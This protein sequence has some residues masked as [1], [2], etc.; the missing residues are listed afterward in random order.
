[1][2]RR[3]N[4]ALDEL[5]ATLEPH[6][7]WPEGL[8]LILL[9]AGDAASVDDLRCR[10]QAALSRDGRTLRVLTPHDNQAV[11]A[12]LGELLDPPTAEVGAIWVELWRDGNSRSSVAELLELLNERRR[13]LEREVGRPTVLVLPADL[14]SQVYVFAPDLWTIR[15]FTAELPSPPIFTGGE[16][17]PASAPIEQ[18]FAIAPPSRAEHEW[19]RLVAHAKNDEHARIDLGDGVRAF[20]AA[21]ARGGL[22]SARRIALQVLTLV[23]RG[24]CDD[25]FRA[26]PDDHVLRLLDEMDSIPPH[27][28]LIVA[29]SMLGTAEIWA[30]D[31]PVAR[32]LIQRELEVSEK[33]ANA[34][35]HGAVAQRDLSRADRAEGSLEVDV[36]LDRLSV[37]D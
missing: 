9:F 34:A 20:Q 22:S 23:V 26:P 8:A 25:D 15:S 2:N 10:A 18:V 17:V 13:V 19:A 36:P 28:D 33:L 6:I 24:N 1:V 3:A 7:D 12:L 37:D 35:P 29:L 4:T 32:G 21:M 11:P 31:T 27:Q 14:R 5:W 16:P 30:S